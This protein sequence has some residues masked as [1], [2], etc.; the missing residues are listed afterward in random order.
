[1]A[2]LVAAAEETLSAV[3]RPTTS[4]DALVCP[5]FRVGESVVRTMS[6]VVRFEPAV[7]ITL[8]E[9]RVELMYPMDDDADRYFRDAQR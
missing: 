8:D 2:E 6:M 9:L 1:L 7:D 3:P 4:P 5:W